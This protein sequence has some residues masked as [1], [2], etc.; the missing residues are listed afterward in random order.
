MHLV[1]RCRQQVVVDGHRFELQE[2][3]ALHTEHSHKFTVGGLRE[4]ARRAGFTPGPVWT[5]EQRL[6]SVHW[7]HAPHE[8]E[9][10]E[11]S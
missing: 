2:G 8:D 7:L 1:S 6:F 11:D 4:L 9:K 3:E 10:T 5:D